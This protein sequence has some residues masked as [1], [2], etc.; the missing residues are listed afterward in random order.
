[1]PEIYV[2]GCGMLVSARLVWGIELSSY[3]RVGVCRNT[4]FQFCHIRNSNNSVGDPTIWTLYPKKKW[5]EFIWKEYSSL[6]NILLLNNFLNWGYK[7]KLLEMT[8]PSNV[9]TWKISTCTLFKLFE[10]AQANVFLT[11]PCWKI[12]VPFQPPLNL[13]FRLWPTFVRKVVD[14]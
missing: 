14:R 3:V 12:L 11:C 1:M 10:V 7:F 8:H 6:V 2:Y 9:S 5:S 4:T 13:S